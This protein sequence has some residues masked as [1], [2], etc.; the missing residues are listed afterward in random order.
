[1]P[2][3]EVVNFPNPSRN[4]RMRQ[5][6]DRSSEDVHMTGTYQPSAAISLTTAVNYSEMKTSSN[7]AESLVAFSIGSG[8]GITIF[9]PVAVLGGILN[10]ILPNSSRIKSA[11]S[12]K[13]QFM[14]ADTGIPAFIETLSD[15]GAKPQNMK[16]VIAGGAQI[17]DQ[18]ELFNI[19][20]RNYKATQSILSAYN[21]VIQYEAIGGIHN[22]T[23][24]LD[25]GSGCSFISLFGQKE[26]KI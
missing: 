11:K 23:L 25:I 1:M 15:L 19:G 2:V 13:Y 22:R 7:P 4:V 16:V 14:F 20:H 24:R 21:L 26:I 9:D 8:I 6:F 18:T 3:E 12:D 5:M 10:L 17:L